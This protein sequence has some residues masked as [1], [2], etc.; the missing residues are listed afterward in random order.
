MK[1]VFANLIDVGL[2]LTVS[3]MITLVGLIKPKNS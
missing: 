2:I 1:Q 3:L